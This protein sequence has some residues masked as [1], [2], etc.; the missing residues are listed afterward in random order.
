MNKYQ[1]IRLMVLVGAVGALE[2]LCRTRVISP[3][4]M[5]PPSRMV[6]ELYGLLRSGEVLPDIERTL[7]AFAIAFVGA[8]LFGCLFGLVVHSLPRV[9]RALDPLFATYYAVP[10][11]IFYPAMIAIFGVSMVPIILMGFA[12]AV[13]AVIVATL[14]GLDRTPPVM[15]KLAKVHRMGFLET[16]WRLRL[17]AAMPSIFPGIK[18][19]VAYAFVGVLASE[20]ILSPAGVGFQIS[21]SYNDFNNPKMYAMVLFVFILAMLLNMLLLIWEHRVI[22]RR[23]GR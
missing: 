11:F 12:F 4:V 17:P 20:F 5:I 3:R 23:Y 16:A 14:T 18:L 1:I 2:A 8:T 6:T 10:F 7:F 13:V 9:R 19:A 22:N 15:E 21:Y